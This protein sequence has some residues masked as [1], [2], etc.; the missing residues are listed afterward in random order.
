MMKEK[1]NK[2]LKYSVNDLAERFKSYVENNEDI[3]GDRNGDVA[4]YYLGYDVNTKTL[5][6]VFVLDTDIRV[7]YEAET[8]EVYRI[9]YKR[10]RHP[11]KFVY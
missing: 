10:A 3:F 4:E 5:V 7:E 9:L 6:Y 2:I 1:L 8:G 11:R